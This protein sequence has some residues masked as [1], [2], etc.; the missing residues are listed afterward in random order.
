MRKRLFLDLDGVL[1]GF[2]AKYLEVF[3]KNLVDDRVSDDELWGNIAIYEGDFFAEL[4]LIEG[5]GAGWRWFGRLSRNT[6]RVRKIT[7]E[8]RQQAQVYLEFPMEG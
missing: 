2:E 6:D 3:G 1:A 4:P 7:N 8:V 5:V